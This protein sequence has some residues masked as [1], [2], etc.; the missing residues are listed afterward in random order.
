MVVV[1]QLLLLRVSSSRR[2]VR[3]SQ[4]PAAAVGSRPNLIRADER[5]AHATGYAHGEEEAIEGME[6]VCSAI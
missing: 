6:M 1:V 4:S 2:S 5:A 3:S